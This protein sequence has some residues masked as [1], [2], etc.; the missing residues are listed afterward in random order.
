MLWAVDKPTSENA[1]GQARNAA[2][3]DTLLDSLVDGRL[4]QRIA[5]AARS[6]SIEHMVQKAQMMR[7]AVEAENSTD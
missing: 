3:I 5:D 4:A 1:T 7:S 6:A 2:G